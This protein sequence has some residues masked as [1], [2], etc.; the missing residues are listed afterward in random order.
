MKNLL[1][2]SFLFIFGIVNAQQEVSEDDAFKE[3]LKK[4]KGIKF[5]EDVE[6]EQ[7]EKIQ[8][9]NPTPTPVAP[10]TPIVTEKKNEMPKAESTKTNTSTQIEKPKTTTTAQP[11]KTAAATEKKEV[12][13]TPV[14]NTTTTATK[15]AATEV[16][17]TT[18]KKVANET[19]APSEVKTSNY[20]FKEINAS[21][22]LEGERKAG[23]MKLYIKLDDIDQYIQIQIERANGVGGY[24]TCKTIA[25]KPGEYKNGVIETSDKFPLSSKTDSYYRIKA[26]PADGSVKMF[27][28]KMIPAGVN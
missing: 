15:A 23:E 22:T 4:Q 5:K 2:F 20:T 27:P 10:T 28:P 7:A 21:Y 11:K 9:P 13:K 19:V 3:F 8:T 17:N 1:L 25:I 6:K 18:E 12:E 26:T 16:I 24:N 14:T